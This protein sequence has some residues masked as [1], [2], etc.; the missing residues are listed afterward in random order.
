MPG[1]GCHRT[2]MRTRNTRRVTARYKWDRLKV[3]FWFAPV[4]MSP[5]G[6]PGGYPGIHFRRYLIGLH[7]L[8]RHANLIQAEIQAD[9][10][11]EDDQLPIYR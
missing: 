9:V 7:Y 8:L 5:S 11:I 3:S 2:A 4:V 1:F 10:I 6:D